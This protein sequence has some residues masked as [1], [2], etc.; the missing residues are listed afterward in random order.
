MRHLVEPF[1]K[2]VQRYYK[3]LD[4]TTVMKKKIFF[5]KNESSNKK[6][7]STLKV[8]LI[9]KYYEKHRGE[10]LAARGR[11]APDERDNNSKTK[12]NKKGDRS[13]P[14]IN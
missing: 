8:V 2:S 6:C 1:G 14:E 12:K 10:R 13:L 3:V 11:A 5:G 7:E 9:K 4:Y